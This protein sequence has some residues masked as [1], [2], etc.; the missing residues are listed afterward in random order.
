[1]PIIIDD[2]NPS[3]IRVITKD[4]EEYLNLNHL[5]N[6]LK[7]NVNRLSQ[8]QTEVMHTLIKIFIRFKNRKDKG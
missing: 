1:M 4:G 3:E 7:N 5:I 8:E 2:N 6:Y